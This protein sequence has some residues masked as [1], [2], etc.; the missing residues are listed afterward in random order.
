MAYYTKKDVIEFV[1]T[2]N[3]II[4]KKN[5]K[6]VTPKDEP[7]SQLENGSDIVGFFWIDYDDQGDGNV[8][9]NFK[10]STFVRIGADLY[11]DDRY[12]LDLFHA[13]SE[14]TTITEIIQKRIDD[15]KKAAKSIVIDEQNEM[16]SKINQQIKDSTKENK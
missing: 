11:T 6:P 14:G 10:G 2:N 5:Q 16:Q 8:G 1:N 7:L 15:A 13:Q 3:D 4:L 12:A 9:I